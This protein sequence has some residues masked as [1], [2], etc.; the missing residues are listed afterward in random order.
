MARML[1]YIDAAS[2]EALDE[3]LGDAVDS[4][5]VEEYAVLTYDGIPRHYLDGETSDPQWY[6]DMA[7]RC[8]KVTS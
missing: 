1:V 5:A 6:N 7:Q 4:N 8:A 2:I 3:V